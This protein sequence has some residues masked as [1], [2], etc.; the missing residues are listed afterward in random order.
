MRLA[1][2]KLTLLLA[3]ALALVA[4][5]LSASP[6]S[7][8][9]AYVVS[10]NIGSQGSAAGEM[11]LQGVSRG[12]AGSGFAVNSTT[13][14]VY[15]A[16]T[17]NHRIDEFESNGTF[18]RAWGWGVDGVPGFGG[19][20]LL[21]SCQAG[22]SGSGPGEFESPV[23]V[24]VDSD[25]S[26]PS[27]GDVYVGDTGDNLIT[28]F[29]ASG[30]LVKGWGDSSLNGPAPQGQLDGGS[31]TGG[32]FSTFAGIAVDSAGVLDV[33]EVETHRML[34]FAQEGKFTTEFE[35]PRGTEPN[36][37]GV[38]AAGDFFKVNGDLSVEEITASG[39][40]V[41][42]VSL[43][44]QQE[45]G[46]EATGL[47]VDG[48]G[49]YVAEPDRV[50][51]YTFVEPG[52]VSEPGGPNCTIAPSAPCQPTEAIPYATLNGGGDIGLGSG[53]A[54]Y[55][56]NASLDQIDAIVPVVLPD[57]TTEPVSS[58]KEL[59]AT[60]NGTVDPDEAGEAKCRFE[61]GTTT[62]L[63]K[64]AAC[65]PEG[66]ASGPSPVAVHAALSG[67]QPNTTYYYRLQASNANGTNFGEPSQD[68]EFT[69]PGPA[70]LKGTESV[71]NVTSTSATLDAGVE[72]HGTPTSYYFQYGPSRAYGADVPAAP[73]VPLG[74][75]VGEV[76]ASQHL[77]G[78]STDTTY[79][80][81]IVLVEE[82]EV[83][84][85][86][87]E[88]AELE[89]RDETFITQGSGGPLVLPDGRQWEMV[90]PPNKH[91][92]AIEPLLPGFLSIQASAAG[93]ALTY[94]TT[95][96]IEVQPAGYTIFPQ[97]LALRSSTGW[98]SREITLP[99]E[100]ATPLAE[101]P[102]YVDFSGDL[103]QAIVQPYRA[104][105]PSLSKE[106]SEPTTFVRSDYLNGDVNEPC[107]ESCYRP[108]VTGAPGFANVP[109]GTVFGVCERGGATCGSPGDNSCPPAAGCGPQFEGA[110]PDLSH[111]VVSS[112]VGLTKG[113]GGG[114]YEW[115]AG[116]SQLTYVGSG[117]VGGK[118]G[119]YVT[120][121]DAIS[122]DGSR[123]IIKGESEGLKGLLLR[124]TVKGETV[125][126]GGEPSQFGSVDNA[127]AM[128]QA[129]SPDESKVIINENG[130]LEECEIV[131]VGGHLHCNRS[132]IAP[133]VSVFAPIL[134]ASED[135]SYV[136]F[137]TNSVLT[138]EEQNAQG[139][140]AL[141]G[142]CQQQQE[143][144]AETCNVYVSHD[145]TIKFIAVLSDADE[146]D[147]GRN[148]DNYEDGW[149]ASALDSLTARVSSDGRLVAFMSQRSLTGYDNTASNGK[150]CGEVEAGGPFEHPGPL[151]CSEVYLYDAAADGGEGKIICAS[152]NP[153]GAR[154]LGAAGVPAWTTALHQ[155]RYLSDSG[156][157]SGR[158][159]FDSSDALVPQDMNDTEDVYEYEPAG[160]GGCTEAG[161]TFSAQSGGCIGLISSGTSPAPS[162]FL[163]ASEN[164]ND[165]FFLT[166]AQLSP[167]DA[168][169]SLDI[170]D[171]RV[172]GSE[173]EPAK[174]VECQG[175]ACQAPVAAPEDPAQVFQGPGN[176]VAPPVA[177]PKSSRAKKVAK[178][179]H[180][181]VKNKQGRCVKSK[182]KRKKAKK[183]KRAGRD[184]RGN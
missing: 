12:V 149:S 95:S 86:V 52:V 125:Q 56:A 111:V 15:V 155:S 137:A 167:R 37:L 7:A 112:S 142:D 109:P 121:N 6:A 97:A 165:V 21:T 19:C 46:R 36:G 98:E 76:T 22:E 60:L 163:D 33:L 103:S 44:S 133:G 184:W 168:D 5:V 108:V 131:E 32:G 43:G 87:F 10:S 82:L 130:N 18:V 61:W 63:G 113:T 79:H 148:F 127:G 16:D 182:S 136:Y 169:T 78:L 128:L 140:K 116:T 51:L 50:A 2:S 115:S 164:G 41:G 138:G 83:S 141:P 139:E 72:L 90:S 11:L 176:F 74:D 34:Q 53:G 26:S 67:L 49:L 31:S 81:R 99:H 151:L 84:P 57:V 134:G 183:A 129:A 85:G 124:D 17:G 9:K 20:T 45:A 181:F 93:D 59:S 101:P 102:E 58:V 144:P 48:A 54:L 39:G 159:F 91:G 173:P 88:T 27:F 28:K 118:E 77:Q 147:W 42:Q 162:V 178:C 38:D 161:A 180:G 3:P 175:D 177:V 62:G 170:Y 73:G 117:N 55:I 71:S 123:V 157:N 100:E 154:P 65:E 1:I 158:L 8:L 47:A 179:K 153:T 171:A 25:S 96:P 104:L 114:L 107:L 172:D 75:G 69:T 132:A 166:A 40:D 70:A 14:D 92:A 174:P 30:V 110:T 13:H 160:V 106:A 89:G 145:G 35:T 80:Y 152:C 4:L 126:L 135:A 146:S 122:D 64:V 105:V 24:A 150:N 120:P 68:R 156:P 29:T 143:A 94:A 119:Y 23:F 66:V